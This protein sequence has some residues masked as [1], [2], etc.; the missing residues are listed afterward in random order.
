MAEVSKLIPMD[1]E[2]LLLKLQ[3]LE[4]VK[5]KAS[6]QDNL[7]SVKLLLTSKRQLPAKKCKKANEN[8]VTRLSQE[9]VFTKRAFQRST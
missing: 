7:T 9:K 8:S 1:Q 5:I 2:W 4:T 6:N 3:S